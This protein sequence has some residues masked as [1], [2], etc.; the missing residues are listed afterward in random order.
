[1]KLI[2]FTQKYKFCFSFLTPKETSVINNKKNGK[3]RVWPFRQLPLIPR[4][5]SFVSPCIR[6]KMKGSSWMGGVCVPYV[7]SIIVVGTLLLMMMVLGG[8]CWCL[9]PKKSSWGYYNVVQC[10]HHLPRTKQFRPILSVVCHLMSVFN[11]PICR[12]R[13]S[14]CLVSV[15]MTHL[16]RCYAAVAI[17]VV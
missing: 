9:L 7:T 8:W 1:M 15:F 13:L 11:M 3:E 4:I 17:A 6:P 5:C 2:D 14:V 12:I 16:L 10:S